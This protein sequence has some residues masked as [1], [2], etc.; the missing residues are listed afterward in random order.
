MQIHK[1]SQT[2]SRCTDWW[3]QVTKVSNILFLHNVNCL[4]QLLTNIT[5][6]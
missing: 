2:Q 1:L 4:L 3:A 6:N 5:G